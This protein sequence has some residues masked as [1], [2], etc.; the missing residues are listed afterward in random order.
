MTV[1]DYVLLGR[2]P[3]LGPLGRESAADLDVVRRALER[4]DLGEL[5][6]RKLG[7]LSGG[8]QQRAVLARV[9]AQRTRLLLLDEPTSGLDIGHAQALLEDST[10]CGP[11][12]AP[13]W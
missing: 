1:T 8:E 13:P 12:T 5:A 7:T 11:R 2:T 9:L 10:N 4:L 6:D 3:H